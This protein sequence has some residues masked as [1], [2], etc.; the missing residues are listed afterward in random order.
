MRHKKL[1]IFIGAFLSLACIGA[2][3]VYVFLFQAP[4]NIA[5]SAMRSVSRSEIPAGITLSSSALEEVANRNYTFIRQD[6][7]DRENTTLYY[8][9]TDQSMPNTARVQIHNR[10]LAKMEFGENLDNP[11]SNAG[12][13]SSGTTKPCLSNEDLAK[14]SDASSLYA[15]RIRAATMEFSPMN[16]NY[17][18]EAG[19][20]LLIDRLAK[21]YGINKTK[22]FQFMF[23]SYISSTQSN[24][25]IPSSIVDISQ[26]RYDK[27]RQDFRERG[28]QDDRIIYSSS[29]R[30]YNTPE[31]ENI[32]SE[33]Y[34][35]I[36][37]VDNCKK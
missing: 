35:D 32:H 7:T 28:V 2:V 19:G 20:E 22:D 17:I 11:S 37:I 15:K 33:N 6:T 31:P 16:T 12:K 23:E 13:Q 1:L 8:R 5:D 36:Y 4:R 9:Y 10:K 21:F 18:N 29:Y 14:Y 34:I 26:D 27:L 30:T 3:G 25:E 24:S